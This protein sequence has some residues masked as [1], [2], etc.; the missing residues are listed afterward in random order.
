MVWKGALTT[1]LC[2][3]AV[4]KIVTEVLEKHGFKSVMTIA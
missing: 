2:T 4:G 3:I 1:S